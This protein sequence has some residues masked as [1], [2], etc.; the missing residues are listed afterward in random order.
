MERLECRAA[1][2]KGVIG[3]LN[4]AIANSRYMVFVSWNLLTTND[5]EVKL[6]LPLVPIFILSLGEE[7]ETLSFDSS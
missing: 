4:V 7:E 1:E 2:R 5:Q 6:Q 3:F